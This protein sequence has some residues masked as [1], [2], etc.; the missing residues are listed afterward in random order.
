MSINDFSLPDLI[1]YAQLEE[2]DNGIKALLTRVNELLSPSNPQGIQELRA[3][4]P[5]FEE[6]F[7][8]WD[9]KI[10]NSVDKAMLCVRLAEISLLES[11]TFRTSLNYAVRKLLP[12]YLVS[13]AVVKA[14]GAVV[15][16]MSAMTED[17][18]DKEGLPDE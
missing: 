1:L 7:E 12:P 16:K 5:Q 8:A 14:L 10:A 4:A 13:G 17:K 15:K 18:F 6:L 11:A 2:R 3:A 9:D